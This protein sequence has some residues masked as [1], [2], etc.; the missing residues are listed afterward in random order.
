M[1]EHI[2]LMLIILSFILVCLFLPIY[3]QINGFHNIILDNYNLTWYDG[4]SPANFHMTQNIM[5][6][7][8]ILFPK[9]Y[10]IGGIKVE[11]LY[12][13]IEIGDIFYPKFNFYG[14]LIYAS[15]LY[16]IPLNT[17]LQ[18]F[19]AMIVLTIAFSAIMLLIFY[20]IQKLLGL[21]V[22]YSLLSTLIAGMTTS[23]LIYTRYLFIEHVIMNLIFVS[24]IYLI[25]KNQKSHSKLI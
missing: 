16:F 6:N 22:K 21:N 12:D 20:L 1:N 10:L 14:S 17:E 7:G 3:D 9:G 18:L 25:L 24:L 4:R 8:S 19:K 13:F 23:L 5:K 15:I 2:F 11:N